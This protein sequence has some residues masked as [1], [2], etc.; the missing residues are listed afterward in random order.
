[1]APTVAIIITMV[2]GMT[3]LGTIDTDLVVGIISMGGHGFLSPLAID[4]VLVVVISMTM[5]LG[6]LI[7]VS[8]IM[9]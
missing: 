3:T 4:M 2:D 6:F 5:E 1:M 7:R 9:E 8:I